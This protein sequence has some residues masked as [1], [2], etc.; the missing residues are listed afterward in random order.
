MLSA[1]VRSARPTQ[2]S[3]N[4][5]VFIA[6]VFTNNVPTALH[7]PR[8]PLAGVTSLAFLLFCLVSGS[9]Y[10]MNDVADREQDRHHPVKRH[11]PIASG[12]LPWKIALAASLER[13]ETLRRAG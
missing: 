7:D 8:W 9:I 1:L 10:L 3:K 12:R 11:R 2:W 4:V 6:L 5:F 13:L